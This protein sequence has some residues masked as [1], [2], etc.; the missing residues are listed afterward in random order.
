MTIIAE[1]YK[2]SDAERAEL[3][4]R[5]G[6]L[7]A[8]KAINE[9]VQ[10]LAKRVKPERL[11][12]EER[13]VVH[14]EFKACY[15]RPVEVKDAAESIV[16]SQIEKWGT[17]IFHNVQ[18]LANSDYADRMQA[19]WLAALEAYQVKLGACKM[20]FRL[21]DAIA[22]GKQRLSVDAAP[23]SSLVTEDEEGEEIDPSE[24]I[25]IDL[26]DIDNEMRLE[27]MARELGIGDKEV[28]DRNYIELAENEKTI[29]LR[30]GDQE[31][32]QEVSAALDEF[33][34]TVRM[35]DVRED[36]R[37][38]FK[39]E[40]PSALGGKGEYQLLAEEEEENLFDQSISFCEDEEKASPMPVHAGTV[41]PEIRPDVELFPRQSWKA[42]RKSWGK[43][44][45]NKVLAGVMAEIDPRS[46][47]EKAWVLRYYAQHLVNYGIVE[48]RSEMYEVAVP[49][50][51]LPAEWIADGSDENI[52]AHQYRC[53]KTAMK[54]WRWVEVLPDD[55]ASQEDIVGEDVVDSSAGEYG[56]FSDILYG[57]DWEGWKDFPLEDLGWPAEGELAFVSD[58]PDM[59]DTGA[60]KTAFVAGAMYGASWKE[61][62]EAGKDAWNRARLSKAAN[63]ARVRG[64]DKST[65]RAVDYFTSEHKGQIVSLY[66]SGLRVNGKGNVVEMPWEVAIPNASKLYVMGGRAPALIEKV[67]ELGGQAR[68]FGMALE[69]ALSLSKR[70][71]P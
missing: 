31:H 5:I 43:Y 36:D 12:T 61:C 68:I 24:A 13:D 23:F 26:D 62:V 4:A 3:F 11:T 25:T 57:F 10:P 41:D 19:G 1:K 21:R 70:S 14:S 56:R 47:V 50:L 2:M 17:F 16:M 29:A 30:D 66:P 39:F 58:G 46:D 9:M 54:A 45:F 8:I 59:W 7:D 48:D 55:I 44:D 20:A 60:Y 38:M 18:R 64:E 28:T 15:A 27:D 40:P 63:R 67:K 52:K 69:S 42:L 65:V 33:M 51:E 32:F 35:P 37:P 22:M 6:A 34:A 71:S 49:A 53:A